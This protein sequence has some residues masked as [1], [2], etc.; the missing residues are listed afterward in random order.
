MS[1]N[2]QELPQNF[3]Q[4]IYPGLVVDNED[5]LMLG[6][7]RVFPENQNVQDMA[8][9]VSGFDENS[10]NPEKNGP[11]SPLDPFIFLP[12]LPY[13]LNIVPQVDEYV[14]LIYSN[15]PTD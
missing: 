6:R 12:L 15:P 3:R 2:I 13:Y 11:W 8:Q 1:L 14:H 7:I 10:Q 4:I 5:P 9:S